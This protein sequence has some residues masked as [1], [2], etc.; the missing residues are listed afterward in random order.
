MPTLCTDVEHPYYKEMYKIESLSAR[1]AFFTDKN[2]CRMRHVSLGEALDLISVGAS[3]YCYW[4]IAIRQLTD[5][6]KQ[7]IDKQEPRIE[8]VRVPKGDGWYRDEEKSREFSYL[9]NK[10]HQD[11]DQELTL[12]FIHRDSC[13][14]G[15]GHKR[16]G[17][18]LDG[19]VICLHADIK[20]FRPSYLRD[21]TFSDE[22][23][24][25]WEEEPNEPV[26]EE[27]D[28]DGNGELIPKAQKRQEKHMEEKERYANE[29]STERVVYPCLAIISEKGTYLPLEKVLR[30]LNVFDKDNGC[31]FPFSGFTLAGYV[32]AWWNQKG[33]KGFYMPEREVDSYK[34]FPGFVPVSS[35]D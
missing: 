2:S 28:Y 23:C 17:K 21:V 32:K 4:D 9:W 8:Y 27:S 10:F 12:P 20:K 33:E 24:H 22:E 34:A 7:W 25:F 5:F 1:P 13:P 31:A 15:K 11:S 30:R 6:V 18:D 14:A 26:F 19:R 16:T 3:N 35:E 29:E